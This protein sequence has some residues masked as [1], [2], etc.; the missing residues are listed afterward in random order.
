MQVCTIVTKLPTTNDFFRFHIA[1]YISR[2]S[3]A[4]LF[5]MQHAILLL[6][7]NKLLTTCLQMISSGETSKLFP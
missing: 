3:V 7:S 2:H 6:P 5:I 1:K 4:S